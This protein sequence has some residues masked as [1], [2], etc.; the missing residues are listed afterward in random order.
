MT[1]FR[2]ASDA[3][4]VE[5]VTLWKGSKAF[6]PPTGAGG[7]CFWMAGNTIQVAI[8]YLVQTNQSDKDN[9]VRDGLDFFDLKVEDK[10]PKNWKNDGIWMDDYGWWGIALTKAY[11]FSRV[12]G[13]D[14]D[15]KEKIAKYAKNCWIGMHEAWDPS[16]VPN[17]DPNVK[18]SGGIANNSTSKAE[19]AGRNCVTNEV[20][21]RLS[22]ILAEVMNDGTF[23]D[24]STN[25]EKWFE[26]AVRQCVLLNENNLVLER[27]KGVPN[28]TDPKVDGLFWIGDQGLFIG[29]CEANSRRSS[30]GLGMLAAYNVA[31]AVKQ[32][33]ARKNL[34]LHE[35]LFKLKQYQLDYAGG[36]GVF[37]RNLQVLNA[38]DHSDKGNSYDL[39]I[40]ANASAVWNN[41]L[42]ENKFRYFWDAEDKEPT[43]SDWGY[44]QSVSDAV[45][46]ASGLSALTAALPWFGNQEIVPAPGVTAAAGSN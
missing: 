41:R 18:I 6:S 42:S 26:S 43:S 5:L 13:Y 17:S 44:N 16:E 31:D 14:S 22:L 30:D 9:F 25:E 36:K 32:N 3:G 11:Q 40:K 20:F 1:T 8:D 46:H 4:Y 7:G 12:L 45:V 29:C 23:L 27:F 2:Q 34:V 24:P 33:M 39:L 37:M 19:L 35:D 15:L 10:N 21:W 28:H 38:R